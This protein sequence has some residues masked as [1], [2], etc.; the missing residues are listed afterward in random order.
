LNFW[1]AEFTRS[2][3]C[4]KDAK[5]YIGLNDAFKCERSLQAAEWARSAGRV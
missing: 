5:R 3:S 2:A 1:R 4:Q